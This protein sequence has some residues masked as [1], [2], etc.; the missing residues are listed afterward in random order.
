MRKRRLVRRFI[1]EARRGSAA[2]VLPELGPLLRDGSLRGIDLHRAIL[3]G[4]TLDEADFE[5]ALFIEAN[6]RRTSLRGANLREADFGLADLTRADL[7][8]AIVYLAHFSEADLRGA[9]ITDQQLAQALTLAGATMPDGS[10]YDGRFNL[11]GDLAYAEGEM[12]LIDDPEV[13]AD[14]FGVS[15]QRYVDG[16][17]WFDAN[18]ERLRPKPTPFALTQRDSTP[19]TPKEQLMRQLGGFTDGRPEDAF[20]AIRERGWLHDG[21]LR[22]TKMYEARLAGTDLTGALLERARLDLAK[23]KGANLTEASLTR[24]SLENADLREAVLRHADLTAALVIGADLRGADLRGAALVE[25]DFTGADLRGA[26]FKGATIEAVRLVRADLRDIDLADLRGGTFD[27]AGANLSGLDF[28]TL[29]LTAADLSFATLHEARLEGATLDD[30]LLV[31]ADLTGAAM[32]ESQLARLSGLL[33]ATMPDGSFYDGRYR[34]PADLA[35][36]QLN[37]VD[38]DDPLEMAHWYD[39]EEKAYRA[40]QAWADSNLPR[41]LP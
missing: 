4:L 18:A 26:R 39:V 38:R 41:L 6:L 13:M 22:G 21:S 27:L 17:N 14:W 31:E 16:Q 5:G 20:A 25:T 3:D 9:H 23:L 34:L 35:D 2:F 11:S 29:D 7:T 33:R 40:G 12:L 32:R 10:R 19:L 37:G 30:V 36:A 8:D 24:A 15:L 1:K 28:G